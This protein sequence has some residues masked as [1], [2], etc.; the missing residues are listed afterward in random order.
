MTTQH[1]ETLIIGAG[2]AGLATGC[3]LKQFD[4]E[5][6][7]WPSACSRRSS[8]TPTSCADRPAKSSPVSAQGGA[9]LVVCGGCS[10]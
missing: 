4:R 5:F 7:T 10:R 3:H 8:T 2:Q 1:I 9:G 6:L